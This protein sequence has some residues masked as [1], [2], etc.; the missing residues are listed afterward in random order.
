M[1]FLKAIVIKILKSTFP[2]F[3]YSSTSFSQDGEDMVLKA[4]YEGKKG[5]TGFFVDIGAYDPI[6]YSNTYYFYKKG[7]RGINIDANP[8]ALQKFKSKRNRDININSGV[9]S[10]KST[11]TYFM[12]NEPALN[13]FS[14]TIAKEK[15]GL[16][17]YKI[18]ATKQIPCNTLEDILDQHLP[19]NV[20]KIDFFSIDVEGFDLAVLQSN[21]WDK[22]SADYI[23]VENEFDPSD[24]ES[25]TIHR[26]LIEKNYQFAGKTQR[27]SIYKKVK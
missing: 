4:F 13:T 9:S 21:N 5:Y 25:N 15:D 19:T 6:Q 18:I 10:E 7:W 14:E 8:D 12:F 20:K 23:L 27:T 2:A 17:H 24:I 11:L 16:V 1:K 22:Y 26:F 3:L